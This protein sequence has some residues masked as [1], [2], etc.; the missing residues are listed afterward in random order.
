MF[1]SLRHDG[2]I[3]EI[4]GN[5]VLEQIEDYSAAYDGIARRLLFT[6]AEPEIDESAFR[7]N[8]GV[9]NNQILEIKRK[10]NEDQHARE[11]LNALL[12]SIPKPK[13]D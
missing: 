5:E 1:L 10:W 8:M 4:Y 9:F 3:A 2:S 11:R 12:D 7:L 6:M 13:G